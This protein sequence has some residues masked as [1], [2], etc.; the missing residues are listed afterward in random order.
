MKSTQLKNWQET[1]NNLTARR[2]ALCLLPGATRYGVLV[3]YAQEQ[4]RNSRRWDG[5]ARNRKLT[6]ASFK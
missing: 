4:E 3:H 2:Q 5:I 1:E 6:A